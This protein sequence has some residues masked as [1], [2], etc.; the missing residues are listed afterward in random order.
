MA[1]MNDYDD[2]NNEQEEEEEEDILDTEDDTPQQ[3]DVLLM[4]F[5][6][7]DS[8]MLYPQVSVFGSEVVFG[9]CFRLFLTIWQFGITG[10]QT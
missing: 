7:Q 6:P 10:R 2:D 9:G 3:G 8:S 4:R 1:D 5:C